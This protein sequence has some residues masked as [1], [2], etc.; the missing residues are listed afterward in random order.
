VRRRKRTP[1]EIEI[2]IE[3]EA[4]KVTLEAPELRRLSWAPAAIAA[5]EEASEVE[6]VAHKVFLD[7]H[8]NRKGGESQAATGN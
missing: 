7:V 6:A 3:I 4:P 1:F 2:E 5:G 8:C